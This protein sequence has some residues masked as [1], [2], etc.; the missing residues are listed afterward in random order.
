MFSFCEWVAV[1]IIS[2]VV[3]VEG[4]WRSRPRAWVRFQ[5]RYKSGSHS[6]GGG[7]LLELLSYCLYP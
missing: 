4:R 5:E 6:G 1:R 7:W 3:D 2:L